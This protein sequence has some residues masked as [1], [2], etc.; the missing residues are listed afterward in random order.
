MIYYVDSL[1][2]LNIEVGIGVEHIRTDDEI[3]AILPE[4][5][6]NEQ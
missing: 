1:L 4:Y 6:D 3:I 5:D 2:S